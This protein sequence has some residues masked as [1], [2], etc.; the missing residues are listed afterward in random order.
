MD[1]V[2]ELLA[3]TLMLA[4]FIVPPFLFHSLVGGLIAWRFR[5]RSQFWSGALICLFTTIVF[6]FGWFFVLLLPDTRLRCWGCHQPLDYQPA[7]CPL[8][9][10]QLAR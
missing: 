6:P 1:D 4:L 8:C 9:G 3:G 10:T 2:T 7:I 5:G